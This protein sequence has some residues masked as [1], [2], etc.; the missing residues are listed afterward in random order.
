MDAENSKEDSK[1][2]M[3]EFKNWN[4]N[5]VAEWLGANGFQEYQEYFIQ[6]EISGDLLLHLD[7]VALRDIGVLIVGD[8]ARILQAV[9]KQFAPKAPALSKLVSQNTSSLSN[10]SLSSST[11]SGSSASNSY[12]R[13]FSPS[14]SP[15]VHSNST[16]NDGKLS[17]ESAQR[18][19]NI[20]AAT[21]ALKTSVRQAS[22]EIYQRD[23]LRNSSTGNQKPAG[24]AVKP[25][26]IFPRS[27]SIKPAKVITTANP[28]Q[29]LSEAV[30]SVFGG[31]SHPKE[32]LS[33]SSPT[34]NKLDKGVGDIMKL[35][36]V[37][38]VISDVI[39]LE[40][41]SRTWVTKSIG[42]HQRCRF[43]RVQVNQSSY[44]KQI[45]HF[46][47]LGMADFYT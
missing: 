29:E 24:V 39:D 26:V 33:P 6:H 46:L 40:M 16:L 44:S 37:R 28:H 2:K 15:S 22:T 11:I 21:G 42:H 20:S 45:R 47:L 14:P 27:S 38:E 3:N 12:S 1:D 4:A 31:S 35:K 17:F 8:R 25:L 34:S 9:K 43:A 41:H 13:T 7:Y 19:A 18:R 36:D 23:L 10:L 30:D 32:S 5:Q